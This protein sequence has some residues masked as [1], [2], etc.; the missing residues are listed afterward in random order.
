G[1][2]KFELIEVGKFKPLAASARIYSYAFG[3]DGAVLFTAPWSDAG[4]IHYWDVRTGHEGDIP[5][6]EFRFSAGSFEASP[7]GRFLAVEAPLPTR[8]I[9][10]YVNYVPN[11]EWLTTLLA[12][13]PDEFV[14]VLV[15]DAATKRQ[16]ASF[17][18]RGISRHPFSWDG[19]RLAVDSHD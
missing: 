11:W 12:G 19:S 13:T 9:P 8:P 5:L 1:G 18:Q 7:D 14:A 16:V 2:A 6:Q 15:F 10:T 3:L 17:P 4:E